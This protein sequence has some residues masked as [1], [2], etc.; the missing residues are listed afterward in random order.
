MADRIVI[1][2]DGRIQQVG[3]VEDLYNRPANRFV[4]DALTR[5]ASIQRRQFELA[6]DVPRSYLTIVSASMDEE[7]ADEQSRS[8]EQAIDE[9]EETS[10][11]LSEAIERNRDAGDTATTIDDLEEY[12]DALEAGTELLVEVHRHVETEPRPADDP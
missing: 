5:Q 6:R 1:L 4:G 7:R 12:V 9:F 11:R 10:A 3:G 2:R 8:I